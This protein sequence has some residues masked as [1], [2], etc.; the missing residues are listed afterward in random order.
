MANDNLVAVEIT[1]EEKAT[2]ETALTNLDQILT[3]KLVSLTTDDRVKRMKM[4]DGSVP[5]VEKSLDY[6]TSNPE[7]APPYMYVPGLGVDLKAVKDLLPIQRELTQLMKLLDDTILLSGS[8]AMVASLAYYA[9]VRTAAKMGIR[10]AKPIYDDLK[11]RFARSRG[12][13]NTEE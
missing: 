8:E 4:G 10:D 3:P 11:Q 12:S 1:T 2:V 7:F 6:A 9:S 5:F 13:S